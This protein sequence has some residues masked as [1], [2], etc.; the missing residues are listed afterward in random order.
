MMISVQRICAV[1]V[2]SPQDTPD[3]HPV[4]SFQLQMGRLH[5]E[6]AGN[7]VIVTRKF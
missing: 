4:V 1:H 6:G 2:G 7:S 3:Y 5:S